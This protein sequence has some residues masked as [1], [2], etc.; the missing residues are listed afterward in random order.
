MAS[1]DS[2]I[3]QAFK[4]LQFLEFVN[5]HNYQYLDWQVTVAFYSTLHFVNA[6]L[7]TKNIHYSSHNATKH[8]L[9]PE[10]K[11]LEGSIPLRIYESYNLLMM[12][13]RRA[14]YLSDHRNPKSR[15]DQ[16]FPT[17][18]KHLSQA[19]RFLDEIVRYFQQEY[20]LNDVPSLKIH[21]SRLVTQG[22]LEVPSMERLSNV[23]PG[24]LIRQMKSSLS[25][26][27]INSMSL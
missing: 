4:N 9:N 26:S 14:R 5:A 20:N 22:F 21:C 12:L 8:A 16:V 25:V 18:E 6:H 2:H 3:E 17:R 1:F 7:A 13:S 11:R 19:V 27:F 15:M 23:Q 10:N 24:R